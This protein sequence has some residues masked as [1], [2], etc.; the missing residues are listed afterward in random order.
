MAILSDAVISI[1]GTDLSAYCVEATLN[2]DAEMQDD[3]AMGDIARSNEIGLDVWSLSLKFLTPFASGGPDS[4][5][6]HADN[7]GIGKT[8]AIIFS[9][10][11][12][13]E[14][15]TNPEW[16]GTGVIGSYKPVGGHVGD[17]QVAEVEILSAGTLTRDVT[18]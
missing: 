5:L 7:R 14:G 11:S 1:A 9:P 8:V 4:V 18:P 15:A 17:Q 10:A 13:G 3:T 12:G 2:F 6:S 16:T